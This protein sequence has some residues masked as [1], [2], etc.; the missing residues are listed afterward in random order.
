MFG[1]TCKCPECGSYNN[2]D[3]D[4]CRRCGYK[5]NGSKISNKKMKGKSSLKIC[6]AVLTVI[7]L[8]AIPGMFDTKDIVNINETKITVEQ[9][10]DTEYLNYCIESCELLSIDIERAS[11]SAEY[12]DFDGLEKWGRYLKEDSKEV[13]NEVRKFKV[14][15]TLQPSKVEFELALEDLYLAGKYSESGARDISVSDLE[16]SIHYINKYI[17]HIDKTTALLPDS[18]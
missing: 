5:L 4:T 3:R 6:I 12:G 10:D 1:N 18:L 13:L 11:L 7:L 15:P 9:Y 2:E 17:N 16:L 14:S 8:C